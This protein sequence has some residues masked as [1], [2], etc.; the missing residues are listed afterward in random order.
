MA[1]AKTKELPEPYENETLEDYGERVSEWAEQRRLRAA[2][3]PAASDVPHD[4][5]RVPDLKRPSWCPPRE[6]MLIASYCGDDNDACTKAQPCADCLRMCNI[7]GEDGHFKRTLGDYAPSSDTPAPST[8]T[9]EAEKEAAEIGFRDGYEQ[10]VQDIDILTG[11]DGEYVFCTDGDP[12]RHCPTPEHMKL[13]IKDRF[14]ATSTETK[15]FE[16]DGPLHGP[17]CPACRPTEEALRE[18]NA[19]W[20]RADLAKGLAALDGISLRDVLTS[21]GDAANMN[22]WREYLGRADDLLAHLSLAASINSDL[23]LSR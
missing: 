9:E 15:C 13:R 11:G 3:Q 7:F 6:F 16:C 21:S 18:E 22:N 1:D 19:K 10:A 12:D 5:V 8:S 20:G 17:Y 14:E 2:P 23:P 4:V